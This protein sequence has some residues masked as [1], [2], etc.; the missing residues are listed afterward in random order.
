[1]STI[2]VDTIT[3]E[4][5]TGAPTFSQG[6]AVTGNLSATGTIT[7]GAFSGSGAGLTSVPS[8]A[9]TGLTPT[10]NPV[11]VTGATPSLDLSSY[12]FFNNGTLT[13]NTTV[14]FSNVPTNA[15]WSYTAKIANASGAWDLST[16]SFVSS[17]KQS[18]QET[19]GTGVFFKPDGTK[20]YIIGFSGVHEY[21]L[22]TPWMIATETHVQTT[23]V[24][25]QE[26]QPQD[27]FFKSDGTKMYIVGDNGDEVNEYNLSTAWDSSTIS[28]S[29]VFSVSS[30]DSNPRGMHFKPDG[31]KMYIVGANDL[32]INEYNLS[33]AW[34]I[35]SASYSQN[36]S[37]SAQEINP[38]AV[39]FKPDGTKM[40][41]LGSSGDVIDEYALS[42]A[43]DI[44][45]ASFSLS[46][47]S[48]SVLESDPQGL[49]FH[50]D[51]DIVYVM[52]AN[53]DVTVQYTLGT[54]ST[55]TLPASVENPPTVAT[56]YNSKVVYDFFTMD[57]GTTVTLIG[58]EVI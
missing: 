4:A 32:D 37:V 46:S 13:A 41:V 54:A 24:S 28:A 47:A 36:F 43:W 31:T 52:G 18:A 35:T 39:F 55:I 40:Y 29:S 45:T 38:N 7:G 50:P 22:A 3:D 1:M 12:N 5:G 10:F 27:I 21:N 30:Q 58:E 11:T 48:V 17:Q 19:V 26:S 42:T 20:M 23:S 15:R 9:I 6:A 14:S 33:T 16:M 56:P 57:G 51:G 49:F 44:S 53:D 2:K 25:A 34:D 8:S